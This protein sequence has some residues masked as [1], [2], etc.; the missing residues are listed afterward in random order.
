M[1]AKPSLRAPMPV[2][3]ALVL[4]LGLS[5]LVQ[6]QTGSIVNEVVRGKSL[7]NT[8]TKENPDR[9]VAVY[10]PPSYAESSDRRYPVL[11]LLHGIGDTEKTWLRAWFPGNEGFDTIPSL[12][13]SGIKEHA[14]GEYIVVMPDGRTNWFG[15][16]YVNSSVTGNWDD[17]FSKELVAFIDSKYRTI[18]DA[19]HRAVAGHSMGGYGALSL[20]M[21]H[22]DVFGTVYAMN[23]AVMDWGGDLTIATP[24]FANVVKAKTREE[25]MSTGNLYDVG[26]VTVGQAFSPNPDNPPF[27]CDL[28][29]RLEEGK[30]VPNEPAFTK[31]AERSPIKMVREF[32]SNLRKLEGLKFDSGYDDEF[33]FIPVNARRLSSE[34]TN[35]GIGHFF[36]EYNG[37]HRNRV[38]GRHGRLFTEVMPFVWARIEPR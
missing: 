10:L 24:S 27:Y 35:N 22:P 37:D 11:Y 12:M 30:M 18:A 5:V 33:R 1:K 9:N 14:F 15:S 16:F 19:D 28:P 20:G 29:F 23:P 17:F 21:R 38:W 8:V 26:L 32:R 34:L 3:A 13:D 25:L 6:A 2:F 36:E 4:L 31:W 7:E